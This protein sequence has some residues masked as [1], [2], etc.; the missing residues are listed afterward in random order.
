MRYSAS[1][2]LLVLGS[3]SAAHDVGAPFGPVLRGCLR[4]ACCPVVTVTHLAAVN[5]TA[6]LPVTA[7]RRL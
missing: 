3:T 5:R 4:G 2:D 1:A 6:T 7:S